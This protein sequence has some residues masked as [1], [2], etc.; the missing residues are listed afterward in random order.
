MNE[1][2]TERLADLIK[3]YDTLGFKKDLYYNYDKN[4][5]FNVT[6]VY[7]QS[8]NNKHYVFY[9]ELTVND[10]DF[11]R[12][13]QITGIYEKDVEVFYRQLMSMLY[14]KYGKLRPG[15]EIASVNNI[16]VYKGIVS[17]VNFRYEKDLD[18]AGNHDYVDEKFPSGSYSCHGGTVDYRTLNLFGEICNG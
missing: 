1:A 18:S 15:L 2:Y 13:R 3:S 5:K 10:L 8:S 14:Y 17:D 12:R 7:K 6:I 11:I 4:M 16:V 9:G